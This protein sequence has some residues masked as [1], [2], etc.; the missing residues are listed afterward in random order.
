[1]RATDKGL[2]DTLWKAANKLRGA[3]S[4]SQYKDVV[5]GLVFL[6]H[7]AA[8]DWKV[9]ADNTKNGSIGR[10]VDDAMEAAGLPRL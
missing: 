4:A 7:I 1:M 3:L 10:L 2:K 9:L 8:S 6:K 5:L